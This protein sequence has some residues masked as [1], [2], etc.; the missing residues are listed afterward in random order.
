MVFKILRALNGLPDS[1]RV[2]LVLGALFTK[3]NEL[4]KTLHG[5]DGRINVFYDVSQQGDL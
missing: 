2:S 1:C 5:F 4:S 3:K